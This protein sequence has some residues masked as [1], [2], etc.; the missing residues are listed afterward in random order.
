MDKNPSSSIH[1]VAA[2]PCRGSP[3][4]IFLPPPLCAGRCRAPRALSSSL[5]RR[6]GCV[7]PPPAGLSSFLLG[8]F[9]FYF[10]LLSSFV[11]S[12]SF[13][14]FSR[15]FLSVQ[16]F[17]PSFSLAR[18]S[19]FLPRPFPPVACF[20]PPPFLF[21]R[22]FLIKF[23]LP[24]FVLSSVLSIIPSFAFSTVTFLFPHLSFPPTPS[25]SHSRVF[26]L[27]PSTAAACASIVH[28]A[29]MHARA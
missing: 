10:P 28:R 15:R 7:P 16:L 21:L 9:S 24:P 13:A 17:P 2:H 1:P 22:I 14:P 27:L 26:L 5:L 25:L 4:R 11:S 20:R 18:L 19:V 29:C 23:L 3:T 12:L 6:C 8:S